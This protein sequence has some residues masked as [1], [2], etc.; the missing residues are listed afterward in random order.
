MKIYLDNCVYNR[1]YDDFSKDLI[2]SLEAQAKLYIQNRIRD[3]RYEL[4]TSE[5]LMTEI[6]NC[7]FDIRCRGIT[8]FVSENS[9]LHVGPAN[10]RKVDK[11]AREIM[12]AGVKYK[13]ACHIASALIAECEYFISTDKRLLKY[14]T[15]KINMVDPIRFV[16]ETEGYD[17]DE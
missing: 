11:M 15:D 14:K 7:P 1:P 6:S 9:S 4:V 12:T 13:D 5:I 17:Y 8:D 3:G 2:V 10:N 16:T